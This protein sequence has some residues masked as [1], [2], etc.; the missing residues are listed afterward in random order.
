MVLSI[1]LTCI[2]MVQTQWC[3]KGQRSCLRRW[4]RTS[5]LDQKSRSCCPNS[6]P[7]SLWTP[8]EIAHKPV[9]TCLKVRN[10]LYSLDRA[11]A[12]SPHPHIAISHFLTAPHTV[13]SPLVQRMQTNCT[14]GLS[15]ELHHSLCVCLFV[16]QQIRRIRSW[17]GIQKPERKSVR[18]WKSWK[19]GKPNWVLFSNLNEP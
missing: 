19:T 5:L 3:G 1:Y 17:Y 11:D 15:N 14:A 10:Y 6:C 18:W 12:L 4:C 7:P 13:I 2:L 16:V 8:W 9:C